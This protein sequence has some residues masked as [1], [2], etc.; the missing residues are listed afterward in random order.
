MSKKTLFKKL[1]LN[2]KIK[3]FFATYHPVTLEK[4]NHKY[5][6]KNFL[7]AINKSKYQCIFTYPNF[8]SGDKLIIDEIKKLTK[9]NKRRY[10]FLKKLDLLEYASVLKHCDAIG[11]SSLGIVDS[12]LFKKPVINIGNRQKGKIFSKNIIQSKNNS[13][14]IINSINFLESKNLKKHQKLKKPI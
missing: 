4:D 11:N 14:D 9:S 5:Q 7:N 10:I 1:N 3:T 2:T 6:I 8:D 12:T 13:N